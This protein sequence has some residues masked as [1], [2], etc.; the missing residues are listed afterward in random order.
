M[1]MDY[2]DLIK[3]AK[4]NGVAT[5]KAMYESIDSLNEMLCMMKEEH[6]QMY[7]DFMRKQHENLYGC[8]YDKHFAEMDVEKIR[9]TVGGEK[10]TGAHWSVDQ[11]EEATRNTSFPSGTTK[12]DKY[13]AF[14]SFYADLCTVLD[15]AQVLKCAHRFY[16]ADED[17][18]NGKIWV[19]MGAMLY[20]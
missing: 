20:E 10:K 19:Y 12:W 18:P 5:E 6:P 7:W 17:A 3:N 8:H 16:F 4:A 14:N 1:G 11:I 13:V 9:Y 15:E 2:K